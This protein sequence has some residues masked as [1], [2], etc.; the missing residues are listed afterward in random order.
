MNKHISPKSIKDL[1]VTMFETLL[2]TLIDPTDDPA[3]QLP[4]IRQA[5]DILM[6]DNNLLQLDQYAQNTHYFAYQLYKIFKVFFDDLEFSDPNFMPD[7]INEVYNQ[8]FTLVEMGY[9]NAKN[10]QLPPKTPASYE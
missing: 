5:K 3:G 1:N 9:K 8:S 10:I 7:Y 4:R 6:I 2:Q